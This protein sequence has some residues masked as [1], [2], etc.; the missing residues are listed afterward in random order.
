MPI[1][2]LYNH[3]EHRKNLAHFASLASLA[4][5]DGEVN[6]EEK[7]VLDRFAYK[8]GISESEYKEVMK[9]ENKYPFNPSNSLEERLERLHDLFRII[10]ADHDIDDEEM[11][12]LKKYALGLGF[13]DKKADRIIEKSV[14]IFSGRIDFD[15]YLLLI[16]NQ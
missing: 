6:P 5:V 7:R 3:S 15:D 16:T 1:L 10:F 9:K 8:M 13:P 12:L 4:A 2:D 14:A 11:I